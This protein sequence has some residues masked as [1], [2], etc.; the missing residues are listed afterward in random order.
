M[1]SAVLRPALP[2][3]APPG[4]LLHAHVDRLGKGTKEGVRMGFQNLS[5]RDRMIR[6]LAGLL[7]YGV[8]WGSPSAE[9][10][11]WPVALLLFS[12]F[13][14]VTGILGWCPVYTILCLSTWKPKPRPRNP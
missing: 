7:M 6:L 1:G 3:V 9:E 2:D 5:S 10:A 11:I 4:A 8:G 12:W 14:L 13:P